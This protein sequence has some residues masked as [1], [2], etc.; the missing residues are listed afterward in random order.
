MGPEDKDANRA[1]ESAALRYERM[2][3]AAQHV[4]ELPVL[5]DRAADNILGYDENGLP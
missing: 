4:A 5:D 3:E 2:H 1:I